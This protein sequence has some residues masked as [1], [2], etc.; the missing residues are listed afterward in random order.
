MNVDAVA[1][2][3]YKHIFVVKC[4]AHNAGSPVGKGRHGIEQMGRLSG[5]RRISGAGRVIVRHGMAQRNGDALLFSTTDELHRT[6]L[7]R[8]NG[9]QFDQSLALLLQ[10]MEHLRVRVVEK[11]LILSAF[12]C[13]AQ[14]R[15]LQIDAHQFRTGTGF[16][17]VTGRIGTN[18]RQLLF[19]R[20]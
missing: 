5:A 13:L 4:C 18:L 6:R 3:F 16:P 8:R 20:E 10:A 7:F 17:P 2:Q 12:L 11:C 19:R 9:H 14:E 1:N 15:S